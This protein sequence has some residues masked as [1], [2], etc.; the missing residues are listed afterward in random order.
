MVSPLTSLFSM[1]AAIRGSLQI[2]ATQGSLRDDLD[3]LISFDDLTEIV[4]LPDI[5]ATDERY[6]G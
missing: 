3:R 1:V 5:A 2:L 4:G 6:R